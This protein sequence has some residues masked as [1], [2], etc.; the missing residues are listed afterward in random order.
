MTVND[1]SLGESGSKLSKVAATSLLMGVTRASSEAYVPEYHCPWAGRRLRT[2]INKAP[3]GIVFLVRRFQDIHQL[4]LNE[5]QA[6]VDV[7]LS[8]LKIGRRRFGDTRNTNLRIALFE[9][10]LDVSEIVVR[11][12]QLVADCLV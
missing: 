3:G 12:I 5:Y 10:I 8:L 6:V 4:W 2:F 11:T 9:N 1:A 7:G